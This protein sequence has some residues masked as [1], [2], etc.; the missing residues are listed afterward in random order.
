VVG[1]DTFLEE[2]DVVIYGCWASGS[3]WSCG[4]KNNYMKRNF[5]ETT[6]PLI[7]EKNIFLLVLKKTPKKFIYEIILN[8]MGN[9]KLLK[10]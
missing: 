8:S 6:C 2:I 5:S 9:C 1:I 7:C 10:S 3:Q 4:T